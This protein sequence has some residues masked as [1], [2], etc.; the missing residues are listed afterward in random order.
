MR[1][2]GMSTS[3]HG[4][5]ITAVHMGMLHRKWACCKPI[6]FL[7]LCPRPQSLI[8]VGECN[9][10]TN[11]PQPYITTSCAYSQGGR[12]EEK[13]LGLFIYQLWWFCEEKTH[14]YKSSQKSAPC[15]LTTT[16]S[17]KWLCCCSDY[18][19]SCFSNHL[20]RNRSM[21]VQTMLHSTAQIFCY[22]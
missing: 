1:L 5:H 15:L 18:E 12:S 8:R 22:S 6:R 16:K 2:C 11:T 19:W 9:R 21:W 13:I 10:T 17:L 14:N 3:V 20:F 7:F 4:R